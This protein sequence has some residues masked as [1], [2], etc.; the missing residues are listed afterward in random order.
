MATT[1]IQE[2]SNQ[3]DSFLAKKM[4]EEG[5]SEEEAKEMRKTE[6]V[7][8]TVHG[9]N[10]EML[11]VEGLERK[12]QADHGSKRIM[13]PSTDIL[14]HQ[15]KHGL[16]LDVT[17]QEASEDM[18]EQFKKLAEPMEKKLNGKKAEVGEELK[19]FNENRQ[20][21]AETT[22]KIIQIFETEVIPNLPKP[23]L[24][25]MEKEI[26]NALQETDFD[27][28]RSRIYQNLWSIIHG[29]AEKQLL[30]KQKAS[31]MKWG[32]LRNR[33]GA[34]GE[35]KVALAM[36]Q[37]MEDYM[38]MSVSGMKTTTY[39]Y[40]LL[41]SLNIK[42]TH[43]TIRDPKTNKVKKQDEVEHDHLSTWVEENELVVNFVQVKTM[44]VKPWNPPDQKRVEEAT[45]E[46]AKH[47]LLQMIKD[48]LTFKELFPDVMVNQMKKIRYLS[49]DL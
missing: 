30:T 18:A 10:T 24:T 49:I 27:V 28:Q 16:P 15:A 14:Q 25:K 48:V 45:F 2:L 21:E 40:D 39:L 37:V 12:F 11:S 8:V 1:P 6:F 44:E 42:L 32:A 22:R 3:L 9:K 41:E 13:V 43:R 20:S 5:L 26:T 23:V 7:E 19:S 4:L 38:G 35:N 47:G 33:K 36:N 29:S 17:H 34:V 46:H 31:K